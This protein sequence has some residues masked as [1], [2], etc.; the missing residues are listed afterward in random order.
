M[1][2]PM[3][4]LLNFQSL[5]KAYL[6][7]YRVM[8]GENWND[9]LE[10]VSMERSITNQCI[11]G[12]SYEDYVANGYEAI[13][14]GKRKIATLYFFSYVFIIS[15]IFMNILIAIILSVYFTMSDDARH[16][17]FNQI[18]SNFK[19]AWSYFDPNAKG[20]ISNENIE[21]FLL[22]LG[23]PLGMGRKY[24]NDKQKMVAFMAQLEKRM[25][26]HLEDPESRYFFNE[27]LDY[28]IVFFVVKQ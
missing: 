23:D 14:C 19:N 12:P 27:V 25:L 3:Q 5:P 18:L 20:E 24:T 6:S 1:N 9:L 7:L 21:A 22:R 13:G 10:A 16:E 28:L 2:G 11:N 26:K 17:E 4:S 15:I 8:T